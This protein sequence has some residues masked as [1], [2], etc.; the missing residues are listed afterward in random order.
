[1]I[2]SHGHLNDPKLLPELE[3]IMA[4]AAAA[5]V[6]AFVVPGYDLE[7]SLQAVSLGERY[8]NIYG[9]VGIHPHDALT[10]NEGVENTFRELL[11]HPKVVGLGEIGL[12]YYYDNSPREVQQE[13]FIAQLRLAKEAGKPVVIHSRDAFLDTFTIIKEHGQGLT[14]VFHC[15]QGSYESA[16]RVIRELGFSISLGGPVTF[17]AAKDPLDV[18]TRIPLDYLLLETDCPYL[19]PHPFRGKVNEPAYLPLIAD[20][21]SEARGVDVRLATKANTIALFGLEI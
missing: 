9:L 16:M 18:A 17:K 10:Y 6:E 20:K 8:G 1:M 7:S 12:D 13:V 2:D 3:A 5:G 15:F 14:G 19:T 11:Q 4:R 21:I